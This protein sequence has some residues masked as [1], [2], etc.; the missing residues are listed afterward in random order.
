MKVIHLVNGLLMNAASFFQLVKAPTSHHSSTRKKSRGERY[1][2]IRFEY[3]FFFRFQ[4]D[5]CRRN[6]VTWYLSI[7]RWRPFSEI[8][9]GSNLT[10]L[11]FD[12]VIFEIFVSMIYF[13][14]KMNFDLFIEYSY[15]TFFPRICNHFYIGFES[16]IM[17]IIFVPFIAFD[18][19]KTF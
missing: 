10:S 9:F 18:T 11:I 4:I 8:F 6:E 13:I 12:G 2:V 17:S 3:R 5:R 1:F 19:R 16:L 14:Y 15:P 7:S